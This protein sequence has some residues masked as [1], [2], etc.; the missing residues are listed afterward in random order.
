MK[1][2]RKFILT[3]IRHS[4]EKK[5]SPLPTGLILIAR[6]PFF[7]AA[8][9]DVND[10]AKEK[11]ETSQD[12]NWSKLLYSASLKKLLSESSELSGSISYTTGKTMYHCRSGWN[13]DSMITSIKWA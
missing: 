4:L 8:L 6:A 1:K 10:Q 13:E 9:Y 5:I 3:K 12:E 7:I 2:T 11:R